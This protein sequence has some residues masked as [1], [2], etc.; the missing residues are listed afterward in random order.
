LNIKKDKI[1]L[2]GAIMGIASLFTPL[3]S[4]KPNRVDDGIPL[5]WMEAGGVFPLFLLCFIL[6]ILVL[7]G[8]HGSAGKYHAL[9]GVLAYTLFTFTLILAGPFSSALIDESLPYGRITLSFGFWMMMASASM[10]LTSVLYQIENRKQKFLLQVIPLIIFLVIL[11]GGYLNSL[12]LTIEFLLKKERVLKEVLNHLRLSGSAV[13]LSLCIGIPLGILSAKSRKSEKPIFYF[14]NSVQT[15]PSLALFGLLIAPL[16]Y[17]SFRFPFL[18]EIGIQGIGNAPALIALTLYALLPIA[19]N[20]WIGLSVIDKDIL[21]AGK[22]MGMGLWQLFFLVEIPLALPILLTGIRISAI[23]AIGNTAVAALIGAGGLGIFIFQ[24]L[25]QG[26]PDLILL[27]VLPVISLA[28]LLDRVLSLI[29]R[30]SVSPG[31]RTERK[32]V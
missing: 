19:R 3:V 22:G 15:I 16:S 6:I 18:R 21:Q 23:Q 1:T 13:F 26:A 14:L 17:L 20:T 4:L 28:V 27:G 31:L 32:K 30:L 29:I 9:K 2:T 5:S 25:G 24:G 10:V 11:S 7:A 8:I 12:S